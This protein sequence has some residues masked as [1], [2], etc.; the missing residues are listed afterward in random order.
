MARA[1]V[2]CDPCGKPALLLWRLDYRPSW[3]VSCVNMLREVSTDLDSC[4]SLGRPSCADPRSLQRSQSDP[5]RLAGTGYA[6]RPFERSRR[7]T[8]NL[9]SS[10]A[11]W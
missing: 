10:E 5:V 3:T 4:V 6:A 2:H 1:D 9:L 11:G 8:R 7:R